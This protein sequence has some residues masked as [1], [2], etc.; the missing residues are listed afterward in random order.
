MAEATQE[1]TGSV[2]TNAVKF[3]GETIV[4][5]TSLLL[6]G[7][8]GSGAVHAVGGIVGR[9]FLGPIGYIAFAANSFTKSVTG[10]GI[11]GHLSAAKEEA[12]E[13]AKN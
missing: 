12:E 4:P 3:I 6:D 11:I 13:E 2:G 5:G 1:T 10:K 7:Q 9:A 8:V